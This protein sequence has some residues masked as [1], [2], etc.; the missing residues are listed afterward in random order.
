MMFFC[1]VLPWPG[2]SATNALF[3]R[4]YRDEDRIGFPSFDYVPAQMVQDL[5]ILALNPVFGR[6]TCRHDHQPTIW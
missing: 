6:P 2:N 1:C 5:M 3:D 4:F